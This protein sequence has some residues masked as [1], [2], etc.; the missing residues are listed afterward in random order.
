MEPGEL[1]VRMFDCLTREDELGFAALCLQ[2]GAGGLA[3]RRDG[4]ELLTHAVLRG[5]AR[6]AHALL[7]LGVDPNIPVQ[8]WQNT[9]PATTPLIR[10]AVLQGRGQIA[11]DLFRHGARIHAARFMNMVPADDDPTADHSD[12]LGWRFAQD[13]VLAPGVGFEEIAELTT[14]FTQCSPIAL[15]CAAMV[16]GRNDLATQFIGR[17]NGLRWSRSDPWLSPL[18]LA[19]QRGLDHLIAPL[20]RGGIAVNSSDRNRRTAL[21]HAVGSE[22]S[23]PESQLRTVRVLLECSA[24]PELLDGDRMNAYRLAA[25][26]R[27]TALVELLDKEGRQHGP[28]QSREARASNVRDVCLRYD[29]AEGLIYRVGI[30]DQPFLEGGDYDGCGPC[31][32]EHAAATLERLRQA[33]PHLAWFAPFLE[34]LRV[35]R[36]FPFDRLVRSSAAAEFYGFDR[37]ANWDH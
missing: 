20:V 23:D 9:N 8:H 24:I 11:L 10:L 19:A 6:P 30:P 12:P 7:E 27:R 16:T 26:S 3:P 29:K 18:I 5:Q 25:S 32:I 28:Q 37:P 33:S 14:D 21:H 15:A 1:A 17:R 2:P 22:L 4:R 36:E 13:I 34:M 31:S 35:G